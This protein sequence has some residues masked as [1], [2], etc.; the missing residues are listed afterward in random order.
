M[1][2]T[3]ELEIP[4]LSAEHG[5]KLLKH[6]LALYVLFFTEMWERFSYYGMRALL[7]LYLVTEVAGGGLG[8]TRSDATHLYG[9]YTGLVYITP[10][11]GGILADKYLGFKKAII[12]GGILMTLGHISLAFEMLPTFYMGLI[13]LIFGNG[14]FKPNISSVVGQLYPDGSPLKDSAYTIF[15]MGINTGAFLGTLLCG[16]LGEN[17]GWHYGFGAAGVFMAFGLAQF[18]FAKNILG[19][20]GNAPKVLGKAEIDIQKAPLTIVERQRLIVVLVFAFF[21]IFFW[22]AFEQAGSSM[23]IFAYDYTD[24]TLDDAF[25]IGMFKGFSIVLALLPIVLLIWLFFQMYNKIGKSYPLAILSMFL[26]VAVLSVAMIWILKEQ[27]Y[28]TALEIPA[29]WFQ[30]FNAFFIIT[31]APLFSLVWLK[32]AKTKFNPSGPIKFALG[33][34]FLGLGFLVLVVGASIIP[35]GATTATV[36]MWYLTA[37]YLLHTIGE[38]CLSPVGL[39]L[40]NKLSPKKLLGIMFGIWFGA[41]ALANYAGG[42]IA[43]FMDKVSADSSLGDFFMIFVVSSIGAAIVL[44]LLSP[45][46]KRWMHGVE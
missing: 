43:G 29:S 7:V 26:S 14:F 22:L 32:L 21:T 45:W 37:A 36:S 27:W 42:A 19:N 38:L 9:W 40:V 6:P 18:Y 23:N 44:L 1:V 2:K 41:T 4:E 11:L 30:S 35:S 16:Y 13:L 3:P 17:V 20:I 5:P 24:R 12:I 10:I 25:S 8:W 39:S 33:L 15:Y 28:S 31:L 46:L 34:I